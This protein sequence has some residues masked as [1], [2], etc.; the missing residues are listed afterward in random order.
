MQAA[1]DIL[2]NSIA[3]GVTIDLTQHER[4]SGGDIEDAGRGTS[5][6]GGCAD[7]LLR[8]SRVAGMGQD[9]RRDVKTISRV[10]TAFEEPQRIELGENGLYHV[11]G[12]ASGC[13]VHDLEHKIAALWPGTHLT[14]D[15]IIERTDASRSNTQRALDNLIRDG[16]ICSTGEGKKGDPKRYRGVE[17]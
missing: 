15:E 2:Q 9:R 14:L 10:W 16:I 1:V 7:V 5:A 11:V 4:K 17:P 12:S 6:L 3:K 8:I 13:S